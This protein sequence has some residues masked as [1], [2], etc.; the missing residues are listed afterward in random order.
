MSMLLAPGVGVDVEDMTVFDETIDES[1][2]AGCTGE[3]GRP[4]LEGEIGGDHD[5]VLL[6]APADD[7][8]EEVGRARVAGEV[9]DLVEDEEVGAGVTTESTFESRKGFL[10]QEVGESS[11]EGREANGAAPLESLE[12]QVLGESGLADAARTA[13]EDVLPAR[14]EVERGELLVESTV[15]GS[16]VR[17]IEA[18]ERGE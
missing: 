8:E 14:E 13:Q 11:S 9:A 10:A 7:V 18:V 4:V 5:G 17:P 6:V 3:D 1:D 15:D 2:D 16:W 12:T